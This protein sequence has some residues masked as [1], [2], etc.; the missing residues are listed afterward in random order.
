PRSSVCPIR[1]MAASPRRK[2]PAGRMREPDAALRLLGLA[3]RAGSLVPGTG[4][5][6]QAVRG[7]RVRLAIVA[8]DAS[9]NS[10]EKLLPLLAAK[11]VPHVIALSRAAL[12]QAVGRGSLSA[13]GLTDA[14]LAERV[15]ALLAG[16]DDGGADS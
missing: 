6:R 15:A 1:A 2:S 10:Q 12:G 4:Q 11:R 9:A 5:V 8:A 7:G 14:R 3:A 16:A 13:V